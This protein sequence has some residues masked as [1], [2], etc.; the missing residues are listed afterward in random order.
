[1]KV[2]ARIIPIKRT[3]C[4]EVWHAAVADCR[5]ERREDRVIAIEVEMPCQAR[6]ADRGSE[7]IAG[8]P[9]P[10]FALSHRAVHSA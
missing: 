10:I 2:A 5:Q 8:W 4:V 1:L 7:A 6:A 9:S 3:R